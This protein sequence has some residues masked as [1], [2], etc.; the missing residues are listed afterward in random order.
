M[1][2]KSLERSP[3][4]QK[5]TG[6]FWAMMCHLSALIGFIV[7][8]FIGSLALPLVVWAL[9]KDSS[10]LVAANGRSVINF[11]LSLWLYT[12]IFGMGMLVL[13]SMA[14]PAIF[15]LYTSL[16]LEQFQSYFV[17]S[18]GI[19]LFSVGI[20]TAL[21]GLLWFFQGALMIYASIKALNGEVY[22]YP[23]TI[24]FLKG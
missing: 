22:E 17:V 7:L 10:P 9:K 2:K 16:G 12:F 11:I 3:T 19:F 8:P 23:L 15:S 13:C 14:A 6:Y 4:N 1:V 5:E 24:K 20:L 21:G 18:G